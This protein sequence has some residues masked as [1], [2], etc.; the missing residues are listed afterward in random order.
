MDNKSGNPNRDPS[1]KKTSGLSTDNVQLMP[2]MDMPGLSC[3]SEQTRPLAACDRPGYELCRYVD[4]FMETGAGP[5]PVIRP[6]LDK[7]DRLYPAGQVSGEPRTL[8]HGITGSGFRRAG[9]RQLQA[10]L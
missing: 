2:S 9:D 3:A 10:D 8:R 6:D 5:V 4:H 7:K 1:Q